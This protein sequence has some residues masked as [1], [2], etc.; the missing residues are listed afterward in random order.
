MW[1]K[2]AH[3]KLRVIVG[4]ERRSRKGMP[5]KQTTKKKQFDMGNTPS[6]NYFDKF[7]RKKTDGEMC[8]QTN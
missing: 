5:N 7:E 2:K 4:E 8:Q 3:V 6:M 1:K